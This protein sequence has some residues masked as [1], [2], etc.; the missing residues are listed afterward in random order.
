M[1]F[2]SKKNGVVY[3]NL[4]IDIL[5]FH[6]K[7]LKSPLALIDETRKLNYNKDKNLNEISFIDDITEEEIQ[8]GTK[9]IK[10]YCLKNNN[11]SLYFE[12]SLLIS[13]E[14]EKLSILKEKK[15]QELKEIK[16]EKLLFMPFKKTIFQIDTEAKINIS[17]KISEIMLASINNTQIDN[18]SWI[19]KDNKIVIFNKDEFLAFGASVA[20]YSESVI[21]K[22]DSLRNKVLNATSK[23]ELDLIVWENKE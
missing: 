12:Y 8:A 7:D 2:V 11:M 19:D 21:F 16:E 9:A 15:I 6:I 14:D 22:N 1:K 23:E 18:I 17:G 4:N 3:D 13:K 5:I 20:K 10:D